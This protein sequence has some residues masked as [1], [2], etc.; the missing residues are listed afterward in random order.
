MSFPQLPQPAPG[1]IPLICTS[2]EGGEA[3]W[4]G[5]PEE[6]GGRRD[7]DVLVLE[8]ARVRLRMVENPEWDGLRG[9]SAP[10]LLPSG[11]RVPPVLVLA[12]V[13]VAYGGDGPLLV[14]LASIPGRGIRVPGARLTKVLAHL[15][16]GE[17]TFGDL[18]QDMDTYGMYQGDGARPAFPTPPQARRLSFPAL[19]A[20]D[21]ALLVRT[22]F[23]DEHDWQALLHELGG[24]DGNGMPGA[25]TDRS[26]GGGAAAETE[27]EAEAEENGTGH[28][29]FPTLIVDDRRFEDLCPGQVPALIPTGAD[30]VLVVLAD[31][32]TFTRPGRP[33]TVVD[34]Y[35]APGQSTVL[36]WQKITTMAANLAIGNMDFNEFVEAEEAGPFWYA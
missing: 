17:R 20:T 33:M 18:I 4:G 15:L 22:S 5:L 23:E 1:E 28:C 36:P 21:A 31:A 12:D 26:V 7:G 2:Y 13:S 30:T 34:L 6:V 10:T 25:D 24:P 35:D 11:G 14:D 9:G 32:R 19:P 16:G 8:E 27:A 3:R 29:P